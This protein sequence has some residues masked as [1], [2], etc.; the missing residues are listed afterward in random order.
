LKA[1]INRQQIKCDPVCTINLIFIFAF[2]LVFA[3]RSK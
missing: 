3:A 2:S 1:K